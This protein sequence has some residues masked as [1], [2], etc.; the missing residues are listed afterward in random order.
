IE[1]ERQA[2][3]A[4]LDR[5]NARAKETFDWRKQARRH[6]GALLA[7]A[8]GLALAALWRR[9]RRRRLPAERV[10]NAVVAGTQEIAR[11]A[12]E[13]IESFGLRT[14]PRW[15]RRLLAPVMASA[16]TAVADHWGGKGHPEDDAQPRETEEERWR[17]A[18]TL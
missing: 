16:L 4:T 12:C 10:V 13:T 14:V 7:A 1:Q 9:R 15:P 18:K 2:L 5:L 3:D 17:H 11:Q 8:G 6:R